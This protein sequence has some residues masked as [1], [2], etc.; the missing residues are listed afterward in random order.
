MK[1]NSRARDSIVAQTEPEVVLPDLP[2]NPREVVT[3]IAHAIRMGADDLRAP[4]KRY[5]ETGG[6]VTELRLKL[7]VLATGVELDARGGTGQNDR[8][9]AAKRALLAWEGKSVTP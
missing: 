3:E 4:L 6:S 5:L 9:A 8:V 2:L 7:C 1:R